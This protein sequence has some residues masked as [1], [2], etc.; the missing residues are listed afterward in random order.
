MQKLNFALL[1]LIFSL[2]GPTS[3]PSSPL[4]SWVHITITLL[5]HSR[6]FFVDEGDAS[7][8]SYPSPSTP[9]L[10]F[11]F[12]AFIFFFFLL[13]FILFLYFLS[14]RCRTISNLGED[15]GTVDQQYVVEGGGGGGRGGRGGIGGRRGWRLEIKERKIIERQLK[16]MKTKKEE[17]W[18]EGGGDVEEKSDIVSGVLLFVWWAV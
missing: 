4:V 11:S 10:F 13:F 14:W 8:S 1:S 2:Q 9:S 17:R 15:H 7:P 5:L 6:I 12:S 3:H 16:R 18:W